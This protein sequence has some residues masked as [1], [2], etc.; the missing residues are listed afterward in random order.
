[1][2]SMVASRYGLSNV[3]LKKLC[4]RLQILTLPRG[5]WAKLKAGKRVRPC[6]GNT[7]PTCLLLDVVIAP[8]VRTR[9]RN[10]GFRNCLQNF[11]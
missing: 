9:H 2:S 8:C 6:P 10:F 1:M 5:Y 4:V 11:P 3:G 7:L